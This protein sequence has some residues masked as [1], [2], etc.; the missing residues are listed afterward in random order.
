MS[1]P[2]PKIP[3][4][5]SADAQRAV[6]EWWVRRRTT[7]QALAQRS[8]IVLECAEGRSIREV[9]RRLRVSPDTVRSWRRRFIERGLD[10]LCDEPRPG[11]PRKITDTDVE[12]VVVKALEEKP[13]NAASWSTRPMAA[14]TGLSQ[15]AISRIWAGVRTRAAPLADFQAVHRPLCSWATSV[16]SAACIATTSSGF[17]PGPSD[18]PS[19]FGGPVA[20]RRVRPA[21]RIEC[22]LRGERDTPRTAGPPRA[23]RCRVASRSVGGRAPELAGCTLCPAASGRPRVLRSSACRPLLFPVGSLSGTCRWSVMP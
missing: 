17:V 7:V 13:K 18:S 23:C 2:G 14:A 9:T 21:H 4:L 20:R 1:R 12:R 16:T 19:A 8:R 15:S 6:L 3:P 11:V 5:S 22:V 10:G